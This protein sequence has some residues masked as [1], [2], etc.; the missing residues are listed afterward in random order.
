MNVSDQKDNGNSGGKP[1]AFCS[2]DVETDGTNPLQHSML[3]IGIA[4][5]SQ[6][7]GLVDTFYMTLEPQKDEQGV[8][9]KHDSRTMRNFWDKHPNQWKEVQ[10][11]A[12]PPA[13]IMGH[14]SRWLSKHQRSYTIKWVARPAN[15]DW[16]WLKSYYEKYGPLHKPE[17][18]YY[19]HDLSS[20][21][22]AYELCH[23][24][25]DKKAFMIALSGSAP[26]THNALDDALCQGHMYMNLRNLLDQKLHHN[27][28]YTVNH[29]GIEMLVTTQTYILP[30]QYGPGQNQQYGTDQYGSTPHYGSTPQ[31]SPHQY[32]TPKQMPYIPHGE[33]SPVALSP[34][35]ST[36]DSDFPPLPTS[37]TVQ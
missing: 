28:S 22:R 6:S 12:Q 29:Q 31:Y 14:L 21:M 36:M 20:L 11:N 7:D 5:F 16:M 24:V 15:C 8:P 9:F 18:G 10:T 2:F 3:S 35:A 37:Q 26:Y 1:A 17:I 30:S 27:F 19:C 13:V 32:G 34:A 4:L 33:N 25:T 23:N